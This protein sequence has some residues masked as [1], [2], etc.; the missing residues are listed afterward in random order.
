MQLIARHA[1]R[2]VR[3]ALTDTRIV[4]VLGARQ[5]GAL[6]FPVAQRHV[7]AAVLVPDEAIA[8]AQALLGPAMREEYDATVES[9]RASTLEDEVTVEARVVAASV[10]SAT[11]TAVKAL[12]FVNQETTT[13]AGQD[14]A[15]GGEGAISLA[16]LLA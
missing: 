5:V 6:M 16:S 7:A 9:I 11:P 10:V 1:E 14:P 2:T 13:G 12:L 15:A 3:E 8:A 4:L